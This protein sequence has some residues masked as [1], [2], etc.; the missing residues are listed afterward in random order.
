MADKRSPP[1]RTPARTPGGGA[2]RSIMSFFSKPASAAKAGAPSSD[3]S[4]RPSASAS[5]P[6]SASE[7]PCLKES[8]SKSNSLSTKKRPS[9]VTPVP[10]S[11]ALEPPSSQ[12]NQDAIG[13]SLKVVAKHL[14]SPVTPAELVVKQ[15]AAPAST[16]PSSPSRKVCSLPPP[17]CASD[18]DANVP[19]SQAKKAVNYAETS[20]ED[21]DPFPA[22][23]TQRSRRRAKT[24]VAVHD[25]E[26][27]YEEGADNVEAEEDDGK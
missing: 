15:A 14:P 18:A 13:A 23:S 16:L 25:D 9:N 11:D 27:D 3:S 4:R 22:M 10:S 21:E 6:A 19:C 17:F 12:E 1:V 2:Q 26:D 5:A 8:T 24:R 7:S 20:D